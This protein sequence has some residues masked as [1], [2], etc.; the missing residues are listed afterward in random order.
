MSEDY[1]SFLDARAAQ[2]RLAA[3]F[4]HPRW[5][6]LNTLLFITVMMTIW[7]YGLA[8]RLWY[9]NLN[10]G[11]PVVVGAVWSVLLAIH[12]VVH[13][14]R[15][16]AMSEKRNLAVEEEMRRFIERNE[17]ALD[18]ASLFETHRKLEAELQQ[19][20]RWSLALMAFS[21]V[22]ALSWVISSLNIGSSWPFQMTLPLAVFV[23]AGLGIFTTWQQQRQRGQRDWFTRLP[24]RHI[25]AY[26]FGVLG[27][28]L[29]GTFR[30]IN[31]WDA[32]TLIRYWT[33]VLALHIFVG[34]VVQPLLAHFAPGKQAAKRKP[35]E[36][37]ELVMG[38][39]GEVLDI[40]DQDDRQYQAHT[41]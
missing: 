10:Y 15:S 23:I 13:Y 5:L 30:M 26:L 28:V 32:D 1:F 21:L 11:I 20:G 8:W 39:D 41:L 40:V 24:V 14:R 33:I 31:S 4:A 7:A 36:P 27:L 16:A 38:D 17:G 9:Y 18:Q 37:L 3:R 34:E 12:G 19:Q 2:R 6:L 35:A 25:A 22:N 29:L